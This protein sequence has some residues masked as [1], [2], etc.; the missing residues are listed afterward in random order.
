MLLRSKGFDLRVAQVFTCIR[1][2]FVTSFA[3]YE[4]GSNR[5]F[6]THIYMGVHKL[7]LTFKLAPSWALSAQKLDCVT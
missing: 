3:L 6:Q 7:N 5:T 4:A 1:Q 2:P